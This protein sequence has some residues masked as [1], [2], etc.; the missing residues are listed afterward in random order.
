MCLIYNA[1]YHPSDIYE[2]QNVDLYRILF[3]S[4]YALFAFV[5]RLAT[6]SSDE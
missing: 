2:T 6:F 5:N 1:I 4:R 3:D